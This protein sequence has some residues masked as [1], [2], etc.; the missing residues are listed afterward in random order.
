MWK[1]SRSYQRKAGRWK[2]DLKEIRPRQKKRFV[3]R[4]QTARE[5]R[6]LRSCKRSAH[7]KHAVQ[8]WRAEARNW[9][10]VQK[11]PG[12]TRLGHILCNLVRWNNAYE[13]L[14][15]FLGRNKCTLN[16]T[17]CDLTLLSSLTQFEM[18]QYTDQKIFSLWSVLVGCQ[19]NSMWRTYTCLSLLFPL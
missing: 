4:P 3:Q 9:R 1:I 12:R 2:L 7:V 6:M 5:C 11:G 10:H 15:L 14:I 13:C 18:Q 17:Y 8:V 19:K 16:S